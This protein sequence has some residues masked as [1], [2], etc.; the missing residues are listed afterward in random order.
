MKII[1]RILFLL[2]FIFISSF[3][4][5]PNGWIEYDK[6]NSTIKGTILKIKQ[7]ENGIIWFATTNGLCYLDGDQWGSYNSQNSSIPPGIIDDI[8]FDSQGNVWLL[9]YRNLI[10]LEPYFGVKQII[11]TPQDLGHYYAD[12]YNSIC[13]E[14]DTTIWLGSYKNL[15]KYNE[16]K[17]SEELLGDI[18]EIYFDGTSLWV[19]KYHSTSF[20]GLFKRVNNH[21]IE[22]TDQLGVD[23]TYNVSP[24]IS[25]RS[26]MSDSTGKLYVTTSCGLS[27]LEGNTWYFYGHD[28]FGLD[29]SEIP[30][31]TGT[32]FDGQGNLWVSLLE[33]GVVKREGSQWKRIDDQEFDPNGFKIYSM[34]G[35]QEGRIWIPGNSIN[36]L[37]YDSDI[38]G[39]FLNNNTLPNDLILSNYPNPFN[40]TTTIEFSIP[41]NESHNNE[42]KRLKLVVYNI[43]GEQISILMNEYKLPGEYKL[44][45]DGSNLSSGIYYYSLI[46]DEFLLT[47]KMLLLK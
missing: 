9:N 26:I 47:K 34:F 36:V 7:D 12:Y 32:A 21:F 4:G 18:E 15:L 22:I 2:S 25:V 16:D 10:E 42:T 1:L 11:E 28:E 3:Q 46:G 39:L 14:N 19:G 30:Y 27:I 5:Q 40:P 6:S 37:M 38:S 8:D 29:N 13:V 23:T 17:F 24:S 44:T 41:K 20:G 31:S 33:D 43:L 45:F 35:D